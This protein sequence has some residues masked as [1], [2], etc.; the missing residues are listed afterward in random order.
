MSRSSPEAEY[1]SMENS[2]CELMWMFSLFKDLHINHPQPAL[3]FCDNQAALHI[4]A[5]PIFHERTKHIEID[6]H[7]VRE[8]VQDGRLKTLHVSSQHQVAD[9]LT[10]ALHPTQFTLLLGKMG[11]HKIHSPS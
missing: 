1:R 11:T 6:C 4:A 10:E 5:N 2:T 9:L 3:L 8:K 7:L